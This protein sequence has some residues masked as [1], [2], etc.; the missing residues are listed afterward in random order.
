VFTKNIRSIF[1]IHRVPKLAKPLVST[2]Y[3][4]LHYLNIIYHRTD[5]D[6][7]T[8][9]CVL[10]VK[11]LWR[12]EFVYIGLRSIHCYWQGIKQCHTHL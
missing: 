3:R 7:R 9:P 12:L 2:K 11:S 10:S 5:Y 6:I 8:L 1:V 4:T